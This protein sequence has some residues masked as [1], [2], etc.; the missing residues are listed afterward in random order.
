MTN[1]EAAKLLAVMRAAWPRTKIEDPDAT[2]KAYELGLRNVGYQDA[3]TAVVS[4][5]EELTFMPSVAE[6]RERLPKGPG[7]DSTL[8]R[9]FG[10]LHG[11]SR[12]AD[13]QRR[14]VAVCRRLGIEAPSGVVDRTP[15]QAAAA[16]ART[17]V[18]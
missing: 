4:C 1:A 7:L 11:K 16:I 6:I 8:Y 10:A 12:T 3:N 15:N 18:A 13:E 5:I 9:E 2:V 17:G 14:Y